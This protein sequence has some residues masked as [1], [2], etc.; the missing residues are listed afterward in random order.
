MMLASFIVLSLI[1][2]W[3][4]LR[5]L[6]IKEI[7]SGIGTSLNELEYSE[8]QDLNRFSESIEFEYARGLISEDEYNKQKAKVSQKL[9]K[10]S[11]FKN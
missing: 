6:L 1:C 2:V 3:L 10:L 8:A 7:D 5:P 9:D 11:C 4:I